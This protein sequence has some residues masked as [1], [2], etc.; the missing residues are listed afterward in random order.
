MQLC[1]NVHK[2]VHMNA[3][4]STHVSRFRVFE[5][6]SALHE[7]ETTHSCSHGF[8]V[9]QRLTVSSSSIMRWLPTSWTLFPVFWRCSPLLSSYPLTLIIPCGEDFCPQLTF[10]LH[11]LCWM[12]LWLLVLDHRT[13]KQDWSPGLA[14]DLLKK[15]VKMHSNF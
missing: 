5:H 3:H 4:M 1:S 11:P 12:S 6:E 15:S 8:T 13:A 7:S 14:L 2:C 10:S 9:A